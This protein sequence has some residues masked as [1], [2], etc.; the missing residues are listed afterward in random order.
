MDITIERAQPEDAGALI[1]FLNRI[2]AETDNLTFGSEGLPITLEEE[3]EIIREKSRSP[4]NS[5]LLAKKGGDI[6]GDASIET[7]PRRMAHRAEFGI[8]VIKAEWGQGIGCRLLEA[9]I[10]HAR[11]QRIEIVE[12]EVR[13]DN[14]RAI[15][16][17]R[18]HGFV[19]IGTYRKYF[20][21]ED[22]T[23][24]DFDLMGLYL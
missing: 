1:A 21:M 8:A 12:L 18:T 3:A 24:A 13:S 2:G 16:L 6:V 15:R 19:K 17:Y 4:R 5:L 9:A 22:G 10:E 14:E 11:A 20:K 23:Y 7:L